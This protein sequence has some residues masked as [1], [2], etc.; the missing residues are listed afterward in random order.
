[1]KSMA[2]AASGWTTAITG[3]PVAAGG[4]PYPADRLWVCQACPSAGTT[5]VWKV[6]LNAQATKL[7]VLALVTLNGNSKTTAY[8]H[9]QV[10]QP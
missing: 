8:W 5:T 3:V 6:Y 7:D 2:P 4:V 9:T 10:S 1:V